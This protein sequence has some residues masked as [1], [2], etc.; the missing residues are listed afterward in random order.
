MNKENW[1]AFYISLVKE[2]SVSDSLLA[3]N[4][5]FD[6]NNDNKGK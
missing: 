4:I 1:Y 6:S 3:M 2:Y 5:S